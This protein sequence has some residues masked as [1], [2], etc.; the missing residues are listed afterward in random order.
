[1][2]L[3]SSFIFLLIICLVILLVAEVGDVEIPNIIVV[4][5]VSSFSSISFC[6]IYF[7]VLLFG[8]CTFRIVLSS[9]GADPFI[10]M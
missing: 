10:I 1:M 9:R 3:L 4:V 8:A 2:V 6:F 7:E 5:S